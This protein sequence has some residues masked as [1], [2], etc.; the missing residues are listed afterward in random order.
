MH[1][2]RGIFYFV[3]FFT[4]VDFMLTSFYLSGHDLGHFSCHC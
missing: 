4:F 3:V 1:F 2:I